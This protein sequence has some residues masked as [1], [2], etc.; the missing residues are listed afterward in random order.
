MVSVGVYVCVCVCV[1]MCVYA[2]DLR[3]CVYVCVYVCKD[4]R[5]G[6]TLNHW[7]PTIR[8]NKTKILAELQQENQRETC[9]QKVF[10]ILEENPD[11][12]WYKFKS[13]SV[14]K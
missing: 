6:V 5:N 9:R 13:M 2:G 7:L 3:V 12:E 8:V 10:T 11:I 4:N 14:G 1:C